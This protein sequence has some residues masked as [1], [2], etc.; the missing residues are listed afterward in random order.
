M[1]WA[2][3]RAAALIRS[4]NA[5]SRTVKRKLAFM[6]ALGVAAGAGAV[7]LRRAPGAPPA[8]RLDAPAELAVWPWPRP[9]RETPH[10]GVTHWL[11]RSSA[12]STVVE[13]FDFDFL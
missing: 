10:P 4:R 2:G 5:V 1:Q 3:R 6:V 12:D 13:L 8:P 9:V 7:L 11:D